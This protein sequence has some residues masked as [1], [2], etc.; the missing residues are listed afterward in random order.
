MRL[1]YNDR[2]DCVTVN[3]PQRAA[4]H[5]PPRSTSIFLLHGNAESK[6]VCIQ[7]TGAE[8]I[9]PIAR[10]Q[11]ALRARARVY[12]RLRVHGR[13]VAVDLTIELR[14]T[15]RRA[16][17]T[18]SDIL[19]INYIS[20]SSRPIQSRLMYVDIGN[21]ACLIS[22]NNKQ[23]AE[24]A[25]CFCIGARRLELKTLHPKPLHGS[26]PSAMGDYHFS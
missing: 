21:Q 4:C 8:Y 1:N 6:V 17:N 2:G 24:H 5:R 23:I 25:E 16:R 18:I 14:Y 7:S 3:L 9:I 26:A 11:S 12:A 10:A 13:C 15:P 19:S 22:Y 20:V